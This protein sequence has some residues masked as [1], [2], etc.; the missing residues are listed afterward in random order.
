MFKALKAETESEGASWEFLQFLRSW[1]R[2]KNLPM[3]LKVGGVEAKTDMALAKKLGINGLIAPMVES[4]FSVEKFALSAMPYEFDW[5]ALTIETN[6]A[7]NQIDDILQTAKEHNVSGITIGRAD[8]AAS[9]GLHGQE[10]SDEVMEKVLVIAQKARNLDFPVTMG[11]HMDS[12]SLRAADKIS[13]PIT[14]IETRR[15][16]VPVLNG[17][18]NSKAMLHE[19]LD[20]EVMFELEK[21]SESENV[22]RTSAERIE[23]LKRRGESA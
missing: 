7:F 18:L 10:N 1:S 20:C 2:E 23:E 16:V 5:T 22:R 6:T 15:F 8:F 14:A 11:G 3:Y 12:A 13:L 4:P 17:I 9:L 19:A 21:I